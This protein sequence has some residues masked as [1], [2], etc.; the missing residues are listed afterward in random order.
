M[1]PAPYER[2][3]AEIRRRIARG[4]WPPGHQIPSRT[5]LARELAI[6]PASVRRAMASLRR[7]GELDGSAR[8]RLFV[9]H[10]PAVR[11]LLDPDAEWPY[12]TGDGATGSCRAT[13]DLAE[14]L[15]VPAGTRLSWRRTE[16][17]DPDYR[18]S[19][20]V[21]AWWAGARPRGWERCEAEAALDHLRL[22]EADQLGLV[23]GVPT[24]RVTRT[25][26]GVDGRAVETADLVLPTDRWR[27]RLR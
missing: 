27:L 23:A 15:G 21:T 14:R 7:T 1:P 2:V 3:I 18:P 17:L 24:W 10:A 19:H 6:S 20:L 8:A 16:C 5:E 25:R 22:D 9:A 12:P 11:T 4:D 26:F 13:S